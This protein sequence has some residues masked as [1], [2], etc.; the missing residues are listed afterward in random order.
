VTFD[1]TTISLGEPESHPPPIAQINYGAILEA[2]ERGDIVN[3]N[4]RAC[5]AY[6]AGRGIS[7]RQFTG[8]FDYS[9][10]KQITMDGSVTADHIDIYDEAQHRHFSG[11]RDGARY[12]LHYDGDSEPVTLELRDNC[13]RGCDHG[14]SCHFSGKV[15][16][17]SVNLYDCENGLSFRFGI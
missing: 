2:V 17:G 14:T 11:D 4:V 8:I 6:A 3:E 7:G 10:S 9:Q 16:P 1:N 5:I 15:Q 13:F 12:S